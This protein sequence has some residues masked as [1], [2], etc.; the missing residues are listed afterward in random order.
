MAH[1]ARL[2]ALDVADDPTAWQA[3][4][5]TVTDGVAL[6]G[7]VAIRL[8]GGDGH[9]IVGWTLSGVE[10]DGDRLDGLPTTVVDA[11]PPLTPAPHPNGVRGLDHVVVMTPDLDRTIAA[12]E[13]AGPGLRRIRE[14]EVA[15]RPAR[16]AFF[17]FGPTVLEVVGGAEPSGDGPATWFGL[18]VDVD[19]L[20]Q[21]ALVLGDALGTV[22]VAVQEG[23]RIATFRHRQLTMSVAVAAMDH[24]ADR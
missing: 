19:D 2:V 15:G 7:E 11:A 24:R 22:K 3:A 18:A 5:F 12:I 1:P 20:D 16:Q 14:T 13:A 10:L 9:G 17:R 4:G 23:R 21:T 8:I 6:V